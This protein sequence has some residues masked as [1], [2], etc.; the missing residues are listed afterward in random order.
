MQPFTKLFI[1]RYGFCLNTSQE[2]SCA[3]DYHEYAVEEVRDFCVS[4]IIRQV[5]HWALG[6]IC[7]LNLTIYLQNQLSVPLHKN[8]VSTL[9]ILCKLLSFI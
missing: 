9:Q 1:Y 8:R 7:S 2:P 5:K 4:M 6:N 3:H